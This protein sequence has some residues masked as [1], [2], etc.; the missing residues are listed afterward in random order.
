[1]DNRID[2]MVVKDFG[3][4]RFVADIAFHKGGLFSAQALNDGQHAALTVTQVVEDDDIVAILQQLHTGMT[5]NVTATTR[6]QN[7]HI[8]LH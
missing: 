1:M 6:Y 4:Q 5:S 3:H 8:S 2:G 7:S